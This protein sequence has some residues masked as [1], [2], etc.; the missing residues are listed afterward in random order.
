M[1]RAICSVSN[2]AVPADVDETPSHMKPV[3]MWETL[4]L[5]WSS[6]GHER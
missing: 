1:M 3:V 4:D 5:A 6:K 2:N